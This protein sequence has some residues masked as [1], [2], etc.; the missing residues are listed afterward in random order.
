MRL[1]YYNGR[2]LERVHTPKGNSTEWMLELSGG[3]MVKNKDEARTDIPEGIE[4]SALLAVDYAANATTMKFGY[5]DALNGGAVTWVGEVV[6]TPELYTLGDPE[7]QTDEE[8]YPQVGTQALTAHDQ[9][10]AITEAALP[11][12]PSAERVV[13]GPEEAAD[14]SP[15][16]GVEE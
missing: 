3:V 9:A 16:P 5:P 14:A 15:S 13:H 7:F 6:L 2:A 4:G 10:R 12:D 11:P 8:Y 1:D